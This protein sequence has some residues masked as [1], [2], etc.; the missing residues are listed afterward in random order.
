MFRVGQRIICRRDDT[1][2]IPSYLVHGEIYTISGIIERKKGYSLLLDEVYNG[3]RDYV[4]SDF[5]GW[6][7]E[8]FAPIV[9][10]I[11]SNKEVLREMVVERLDIPERDLAISAD[12]C[13]ITF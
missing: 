4:V 10:E 5:W 8:R 12:L 9:Y 11:I 7:P 13:S 1:N 3:D 6:N 2:Y